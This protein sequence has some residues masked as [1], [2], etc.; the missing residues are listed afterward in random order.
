MSAVLETRDLAVGYGGMPVVRH[1]DLHVR[2]G[3]LVA[4]V[5]PNGGGKSTLLKTVA[6]L[7]PPLDGEVRVGGRDLAALSLRARAREVAVLLTGLI[8]FA[9]VIWQVLKAANTN[10]AVELKKE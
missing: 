1:V 3:Q 4:I 6:G 10:P 9:S 8:A 7:L 5:G 2:S